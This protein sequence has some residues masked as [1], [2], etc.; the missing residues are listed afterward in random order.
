M[1]S[2]QGLEKL[3]CWTIR[4]CLNHARQCP[5]A[6]I[7]P[8]LIMGL[9]PEEGVG[10]AGCPVHPAAPCAL[11]VVIMRTSVHSGGTGNHPATNSSCHR[12]RRMNGL[13]RPVGLSKNL[14]RLD[15][16]NGCQDHTLLPSASAPFVL[17]AL[18]A[19]GE[20]ALRSVHAH[21]A[22][23]STASHP[24]VRDD[25][26]PP[27]FSGGGMAEARHIFL[28]NRSEIFLRLG[29]DR[30]IALNPLTKSDF[31]RTRFLRPE[32]L[33]VEPA[34]AKSNSFCPT[35]ESAFAAGEIADI[36]DIGHATAPQSRKTVARHHQDRCAC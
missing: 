1:R 17:R 25:R 10:N 35:G 3:I 30:Q 23:A 2:P 24:N 19:H 7:A 8:G 21:D 28:E 4:A 13:P 36:G 12:R 32:S 27:L 20:T 33:A 22:A 18:I 14:R 6:R 5:A 16:S 11:G 29:L 31:T 15:T 9:R 34:Q 26:E